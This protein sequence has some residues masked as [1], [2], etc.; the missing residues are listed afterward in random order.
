VLLI[1]ATTAAVLGIFII[2]AILYLP[3]WLV[4]TIFTAFIFLGT[5]EWISLAGVQ[6]GALRG[7]YGFATIVAA[8]SLYGLLRN[9]S[10][11]VILLVVACIWWTMAGMIIV[12]YQIKGRPRFVYGFGLAVIGW[13]IF[14][15]AWCAVTILLENHRNMLIVLFAMVWG[16]DTFAYLGGKTFGR[17]KMASRI[18]PGKTWEGLVSGIGVTGI[19]TALVVL[20]LGLGPLPIISLVVFTTLLSS[21]VGDLIESLAKRYAGAKDSGSILPGHGGILDRIDSTLAAAPVFT[22]GIISVGPV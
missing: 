15:P 12:H 4:K 11:G 13:L 9:N 20:A 21:V 19:L 22:L 10:G 16:A 6:S 8:V 5:I 1:R 18:S 7:L 2:G 14:I 3:I 17:K